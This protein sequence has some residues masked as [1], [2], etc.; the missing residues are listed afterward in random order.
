MHLDSVCCSHVAGQ[1]DMTGMGYREAIRAQIRYDG[2][3]VSA[4]IWRAFDQRIGAGKG[5]TVGGQLQINVPRVVHETID[6]EVI[7]I[8]L[9]TGTYF[10]LQGGAA[11][12]WALIAAGQ[13]PDEMVP[14]LAVS[15]NDDSGSIGVTLESF[16]NELK[17]EELVV[18]AGDETPQ[19]GTTTTVSG[20]GNFAPYLE[21]HTDMA[22]L[23]LLDPVHE[24]DSM[25][26][27]H[28][29]TDNAQDAG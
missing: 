13:S 17:S 26:W 27:P 10:S 7:V 1:T 3:M 16:L 21:K 22:E 2:G 14:S 20:N 6:G 12:V 15:Y 19:P 9:A 18:K 25:G 8:D 29:P 28:R 5:S 11:D 23:I 4:R 24:V